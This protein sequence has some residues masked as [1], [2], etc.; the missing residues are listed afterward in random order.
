MPITKIARGATGTA[1][2]LEHVPRRDYGPR[3][4][5][6]YL[7][8]SSN[9]AISDGYRNENGY[10]QGPLTDWTVSEFSVTVPKDAPLGRYG[11]TTNI[12]Y[13]PRPQGPPQSEYDTGE[14]EVVCMTAAISAREVNRDET[15]G[16]VLLECRAVVKGGT[17]PFQYSWSVIGG[18]IVSGQGTS[19][20]GV[21]FAPGAA[22]SISLSVI[23]SSMPQFSAGAILSIP[24][25][26][27]QFTITPSII[28]GVG[29]ITGTRGK[30]QFTET[31]EAVADR[32]ILNA[33]STIGFQLTRPSGGSV[34]VIQFTGTL[35]V[36]S[37]PTKYQAEWDITRVKG[38][39]S[40]GVESPHR[41]NTTS[42]KVD[43]RGQIVELAQ[44]WVGATQYPFDETPPKAEGYHGGALCDDLVRYV[45]GS[46]GLNIGSGL[47]VSDLF[48]S[49]SSNPDGQP[50]SIW[51]YPNATTGA[52]QHTGIN[53]GG[54]QT[55]DQ[56][57]GHP[58]SLSQP[59]TVNTH[60]ANDSNLVNPQK[61]S[62][63]ISLS[64]NE[65]QQL[66]I[67]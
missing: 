5:N 3:A 62:P 22:G 43:K 66:D 49:M 34:S 14:F 47:S 48:S 12:Q 4:S 42:F 6:Y 21:N 15:M 53:V 27:I 9:Y 10:H 28:N 7:N 19:V 26:P 29:N 8:Y 55:V 65:L 37:N 23:D 60:A 35:V 63:P 31:V 59:P 46:L 24:A 13:Y 61:Y 45:Y 25:D 56:N 33:P 40:I 67:E 1:D 20:V 52:Y 64:S 18:T 11:L 36:G 38:R 58:H 44:S 32:F 54:N 39:W 57:C 30:M 41:G 17:G 51:F 2:F 50:G 16:I